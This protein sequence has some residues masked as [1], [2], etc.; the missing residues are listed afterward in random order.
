MIKSSLVSAILVCASA[1]STL[2]D[3]KATGDARARQIFKNFD[4]NGD[5]F[6]SFEEYKTGMTGNMSP[7]RV[8]GVFQEKDRNGDGKLTFEE[9]LYVPMDQRPP[10]SAQTPVK[11]GDKKTGKDS[12]KSVNQ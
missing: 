6:I 8:A 9:M 10:A 12:K 5:G 11:K 2:A 7:E 3:D 4:T 1:F